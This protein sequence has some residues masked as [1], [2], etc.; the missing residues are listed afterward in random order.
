MEHLYINTAQ[1]VTI[2]N[3]IASVG[4]RILAH[5]LDYIFFG[6]YYFTVTMIGIYVF[7]GANPI[8]YL[9]FFL[10]LLFYDLVFEL[11]FKGQSLGKM[12]MKI[13]VVKID[14]TE[15]TL[16]SFFIRWIF[17]IVDT[18]TTYGIVA[19]I[20]TIIN[21]K[22]QR[23]GDIVAGTMLVSTRG[24]TSIDQTLFMN[25]GNDYKPTFTELSMLTDSDVNIIK[26]ALQYYYLNK[27]K[28]MAVKV[29]N[30]TKIAIEKKL[31]VQSGL[32]AFAFLETILRDY[33]Y[34]YR[35]NS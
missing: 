20:T 27:K 33:N 21:G 9:F 25:L 11:A 26:E 13:R 23:I 29:V 17:R 34:Y 8:Y 7:H 31:S 10:P 16:A 32:P 12:I 28:E 19:T 30:K 4:E 5:I 1:N 6:V 2:E 22:G 3:T 15:T 18:L 14:G 24:K 35:K